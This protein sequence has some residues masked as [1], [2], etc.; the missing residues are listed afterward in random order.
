MTYSLTVS[1]LTP[2]ALIASV[3][4]GD[5]STSMKLLRS[6]GSNLLLHEEARMFRVIHCAVGL[7][8]E[9]VFVFQ[10]FKLVFVHKA[11]IIC[12]SPCCGDWFVDI[13][14]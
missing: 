2:S 11:L 7:F 5:S 10:F 13:V 6:V 4:S 8:K 9:Q 1:R 12:A 3:V 14:G